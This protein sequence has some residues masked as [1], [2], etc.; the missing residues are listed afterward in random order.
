MSGNPLRR[1]IEADADSGARE[2]KTFV[3]AAA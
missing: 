1:G 3:P 2:A